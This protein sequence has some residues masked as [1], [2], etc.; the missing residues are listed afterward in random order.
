[1]L[2][3]VITIDAG[4]VKRELEAETAAVRIMTVHGAKGL[5]APVV[6]LPDST[7]EASDA[8]DNGLLFDDD[9]G[10]FV[11]FRAKDD[12]A[13]VAAARAASGAHA[14]RALAAAL[15]GDERNNFV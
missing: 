6:I 15:R 5:E 9:A 8:P 14:E 11:S 7:G 1:M 10:P 13:E 12:D 2:Y 3:E 4:Q